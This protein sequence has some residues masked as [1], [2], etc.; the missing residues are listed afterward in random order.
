MLPGAESPLIQPKPK[1]L[2]MLMAYSMARL[3]PAVSPQKTNFRGQLAPFPAHSR[4]MNG[5]KT[6]V[7]G[8]TEMD[9]VTRTRPRMTRRVAQ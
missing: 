7:M 2:T 1:P 6:I 4:P 5:R 3:K 9:R 8:L